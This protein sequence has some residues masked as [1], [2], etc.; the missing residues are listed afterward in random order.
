[1]LDF[2]TDCSEA[3]VLVFVFFGTLWQLAVGLNVST[4]L[5]SS[6]CVGG[7][8]LTSWPPRSGRESCLLCFHCL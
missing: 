5:L 1:M 7:N 6:F 8:C 3:M 2:T 4:C